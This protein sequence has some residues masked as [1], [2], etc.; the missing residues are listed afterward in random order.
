MAEKRFSRKHSTNAEHLLA[1]SK[2][3]KEQLDKLE[4]AH[5][6]QK[7]AQKRSPQEQLR[8]LDARLGKGQGAKKE[9][10]RLTRLIK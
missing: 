8:L 4:S 1:Q 10:T 5:T 7:L 2:Y 3:R 6:R 9:R